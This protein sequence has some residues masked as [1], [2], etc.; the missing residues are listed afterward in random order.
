MKRPGRN[1]F[2]GGIVALSLVL[3]GTGYAYWTDTL[4]VTTKATTGDFG[5]QFVDLGLYAQYGNE[6][7]Q[8]GGWS[9]VDGIDKGYVDDNF[10]MRGTF[11]YNKI[12]KPGSIDAYKDR[13]KGYNNINFDAELVNA[14]PIK[15]QVGPY[16]QAK[17]NASGQIEI[18]IDKMYPGYAQAFRSDIVN[19]GDIAAKL[20][21]IKFKVTDLDG[22]DKGNV[23]HMIGV[24]VYIDREQYRPETI[25]DEPTF[26]LADAIGKANTF[27]VGGVDFVRLSALSDKDVKDALEKNVIKCAPATD[28]RL[29]IFIGVA[30]DPDAQGKYTTG[31]SEN[32]VVSNDDG[33]SQSKGIKL[34]MD[35]LWDQ[36]NVGKDAGKGNILIEQNAK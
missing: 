4:N 14:K 1:S 34:S 26:K 18:T 17:T 21:N 12:A 9:I 19:V 33:K 20:S 27:T 13:A 22:Q 31:I 16:T 25:V 24:A 15:K 29:D 10:F 30:M 23:D 28:Q 3:A 6:T 35:L 32:R 7:I 11:D 8:G 36:F 2:I 5:V